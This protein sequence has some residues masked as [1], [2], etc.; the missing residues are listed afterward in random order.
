M[1]VTIDLLLQAT[2]CPVAWATWASY[3]AGVLCHL[4][5]GPSINVQWLFKTKDRKHN[6]EIGSCI[7]FLLLSD[8]RG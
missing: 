8:H 5:S 4:R 3:S 2:R 1:V 7:R 6:P